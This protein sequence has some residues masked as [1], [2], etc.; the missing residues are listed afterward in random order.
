MTSNEFDAFLSEL[1]PPLGLCPSAHR[2][3]NIRR[4]IVRRMESAGIHEFPC[5]LELVRRD[6]ME[7]E[8]LRS[9]LVVTISRFFRN[10]RVFQLL[11]REV[12]PRMAAKGTPAAWSAGCA[13][14]E[15]PYS[16]CIAWEELPGE[17]PS[18]SVVGTDV[19]PVS[20]ERAAAACY[21]ESSLREVP[22]ALRRK[23]F[24]R[25]GG[26]C[27]VREEVRRRVTYRRMDL[28]LVGSPGRFDLILCRNS[29]FT[30]FAPDRRMAVARMLAASLEEGGCLVVGR[31]ESLPEGAADL[32]EPAFPPER[33]YRLRAGLSSLLPPC[34]SIRSR[35]SSRDDSI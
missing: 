10:W 3:R 15:E 14:G 20:L 35:I 17:K 21:P 31:T 24:V 32:F 13:A 11:S 26:T 23:Y 9:L 28:L 5:Y 34:G 27:R 30:Y 19:D 1:L 8:A 4:R 7:R 25:E 16:L 29:A 6:P 12:L 18:L 22:E 33:I 2:R